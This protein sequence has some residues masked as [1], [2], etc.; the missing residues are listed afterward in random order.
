M[1]VPR[2]WAVALVTLA[3]L[4]PPAAAVAEPRGSPYRLRWGY[5][6]ALVG[7]GAAGVMTPLVGYS[8]SKAACYPSCTPPTDMLGIDD[9]VVGNYSPPAHALANV[10]VT[11]LVL[12]PLII[13]AADSRFR[14]WFE[15]AF[16]TFETILLSQ[17]I[18]QVMKSAVDRTAPFVYNPRAEQDDLDSADAF[19]SFISG[20]TS[21]SFAA[22]T[23]YAVTFWKRH[24]QSPWRYVVAAGLETVATSVALLKIKAGY[25]Y[26]TDVVA[27]ALVGAS[28]GLLIPML[29]TEW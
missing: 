24:P 10:V 15:D 13:D 20:H 2:R 14:G 18:T 4:A 12:S 16:V 23:A 28:V 7:I 26:P 1:R 19:R 22:A 9:A 27:G 25:H 6:A 5:D 3:V 29:H 21:T 11:S 17:A 8:S